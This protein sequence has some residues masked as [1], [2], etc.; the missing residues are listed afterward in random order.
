MN[1]PVKG[2]DMCRPGKMIIEPTTNLY[3]DVSYKQTANM[4]KLSYEG[5]EFP[6]LI[7]RGCLFR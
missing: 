7:V 4:L 1:L 5:S 2:I 6:F 3:M